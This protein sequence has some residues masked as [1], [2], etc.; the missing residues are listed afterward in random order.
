M[1]SITELVGRTDR[2]VHL[3]Y[4]PGEFDDDIKPFLAGSNGKKG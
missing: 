2:L 4:Q 3:D 1:R